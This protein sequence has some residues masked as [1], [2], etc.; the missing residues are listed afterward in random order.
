MKTVKQFA[1]ESKRA[2]NIL[3]SLPPKQLRF[4]GKQAGLDMNHYTNQ[5]ILAKGLLIRLSISLPN[6][7]DDWK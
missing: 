6:E 5:S 7:I 2:Y 3:K 1:R 4:L